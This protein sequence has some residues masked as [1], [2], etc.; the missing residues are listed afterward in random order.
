M[1]R[2]H[3][4]KAM[5]FIWG[6]MLTHH[7][8][9]TAL[10]HCINDTDVPT[11]APKY[12]GKVRDV[13]D[14]DDRLLLATTD[15]ISAFDQVLGLIPYKGQ[16]LNQLSAWWFEQT[17]DIVAN[18][19]IVMPDPTMMLVHKAKMLPVEVIVRGYITGVTDTSIWGMYE[20]GDHA[21][22][23]VALPDGLI[24]ND[25]LPMPIITPTT[26]AEKGQHDEKITEAEIIDQGLVDPAVW[27]EVR[28]AAI[29]VFERGQELA[30]KGGL[31]L[32]D[33]KYEF[34]I[35]DGK[36]ALCDEI[37]TPDSSRF[38]LSDSYD[39]QRNPQNFSKEFLREWF[40]KQGYK[41]EGEP[42]V[43]PNDLRAKVAARYIET[44][45]RLTGED[46]MPVPDFAQR[47]S[48]LAGKI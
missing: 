21:P 32:V 19:C 25:P 22:Y 11:A 5:C 27:K 47:I 28:A 6:I 1:Y 44:F 39:E 41:G 15:R 45:E 23:G 3:C 30:A 16:L 17:V 48:Q 7:Q 13:Y 9:I 24:K 40:A 20:A 33:T 4:I 10:P 37:H 34:G 8:L 18:H 43:I 31:I 46:F 29:A 12:I 42:P 14:L 36:I 2:A 26:K 35:I 38:W